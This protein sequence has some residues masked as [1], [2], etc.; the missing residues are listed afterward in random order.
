MT[1]VIISSTQD[2][3]STNI[4]ESL[5][6]LSDWDEV[7]T[8]LNEPVYRNKNLN[9]VLMV[10]IRDKIINHEN[11]EEQI[12]NELDVVAQTA[13]FISRH[14]SKSGKPTL[15]VHPIGN[16]GEAT[17]GG[18]DKT[19]C[20]ALPLMMS[21][22]LRMMNDFANTKNLYHSVSYEVTHHGPFM[23]IPTLFAEVGSTPDEW[24]KKQPAE[25]V[26]KSVLKVLSNYETKEN[27]ADDISVLVG[28]GGGH[29]AP[30][31][32]KVAL[33]KKVAFGHMIP[34][35]HIKPGH[36]DRNMFE[37]TLQQ[38]PGVNGV[39]LDRKALSKSIKT[40]FKTWCEDINMPLVSSKDFRP[41]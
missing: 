20:T 11:I 6:S 12:K 17:F 25:I 10:T 4:K 16:Y 24:K 1:T 39:Y 3:A 21:E 14:R 31:F 19:V 34:S 7:N 41:L 27:Y 37:K 40:Q 36:I 29:Y 26:A 5:F 13:I 32:T 15:T 35:Y 30:R 8:F 18:K 38:T 28:M 9:D 2:A 33:Q 23:S 22:L